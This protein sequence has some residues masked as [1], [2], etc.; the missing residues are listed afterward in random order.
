MGGSAFTFDD[1]TL[2]ITASGSVEY[3][4]DSGDGYDGNIVFDLCTIDGVNCAQFTLDYRNCKSALDWD[5]NQVI[6]APAVLPNAG[7]PPYFDLIISDIAQ[8][9]YNMQY[10][11]DPI[12]GSIQVDQSLSGTSDLG[13]I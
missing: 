3:E 4:D 13:Y 2:L 5:A 6:G 11:G 1:S 10:T 9:T 7:S 12:C 8:T